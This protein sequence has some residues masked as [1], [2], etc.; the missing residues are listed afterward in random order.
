[1]KLKSK[2]SYVFIAIAVLVLIYLVWFLCQPYAVNS[3]YLG[4]DHAPP[5]SGSK[6]RDVYNYES[7]IIR[8]DGIAEIRSW[9]EAYFNGVLELKEEPYYEEFNMN[10]F[11]HVDVFGFNWSLRLTCHASYIKLFV[12]IGII[13]ACG[14]STAVLEVFKRKKLAKADSESPTIQ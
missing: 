3:E 6:W 12:C 11:P 7:M 8:S 2:V 13:A 4:V 9:T 1:M 14:I 10:G 5:S